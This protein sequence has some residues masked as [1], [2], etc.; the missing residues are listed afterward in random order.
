[1]YEPW[2]VGPGVAGNWSALP[3][4]RLIVRIGSLKARARILSIPSLD[5]VGIGEFE[6]EAVK[7]IFLIAIVM[8]RSNFG[9]IKK[10]TG[11]ESAR[12]D[13]ITPLW[14]T[15]WGVK[16]V[17]GGAKATVRRR[18]ASGRLGHAKAAGASSL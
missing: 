16:A 1:M 5:R 7:Y 2:S 18:H 3:V 12:G 8:K 15:V 13:E 4:W 6:I 10:A 14:A 11:I 9:R 17:S